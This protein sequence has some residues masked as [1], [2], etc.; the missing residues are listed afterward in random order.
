MSD[1]CLLLE[2]TY[3]YVAGGV[4][5]WVHDLI[6][7]QP[8]VNFSL[9]CLGP[10]FST[11]KKMHYDIPDNV[12]EFRE[13]YLFDYRVKKEGFRFRRK[14]AFKELEDI[15]IQMR[16]GDVSTFERM[17]YLLGDKRTRQL[18]LHDLAH[19]RESW[20]MLQRLYASE[21]SENSF[22]DYFWTW[23]FIYMPFFSL[24]RI[25]VPFSRVYHAVSTG[26]AGL[27]GAICQHRYKRPFILTE[28]G[29]YTRERKIEISKADW[30]YSD[31]ADDLKVREGSDF[32]KEWWITLFSYF[33]RLSYERADQII[34][35]YEGNREIQIEEGADPEKTRIIPN[36]LD[37]KL[38]EDLPMEMNEGFCVGFV[39]RLVPI[40]DVKTFIRA[41]KIVQSQIKDVQILLLGPIDEDRDYYQECKA[42][43]EMENL[44]KNVKFKGKVNLREYYGK[45]D[46]MVLTSISEGQPCDS[47]GL[48]RQGTGCGKRCR[49]LF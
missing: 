20:E 18:D 12:V 28:H 32:F 35:L 22:V 23:R 44:Q 14:K 24:L 4:S 1:V 2:G 11:S 25:E 10:H 29:I 36:G 7:R 46:V 19:T 17:Y 49:L 15:M 45:L 47:R 9:F 3:P 26:Y 6:R 43:V 31:D 30:I 27:V 40:K 38:F 16:R 42:L 39:G 5:S 34:T 48:R 41:C 21:E 37:L 8:D 33:S 13:F